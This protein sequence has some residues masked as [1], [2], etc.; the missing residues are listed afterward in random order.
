M[1]PA[2]SYPDLRAHWRRHLRLILILLA[3]GAAVSFGI[4][5][6]ARS[7]QFS[8]FGWPFSFWV[9]AQGALFVYVAIVWWYAR[10][11]EAM[12]LR[13]GVAEEED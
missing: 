9:A 12:D 2:V 5:F 1:P 6:F 3:A 8:F 11:M 10:R 4:S 13:D 7:L